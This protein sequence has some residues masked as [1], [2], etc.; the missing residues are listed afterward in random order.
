MLFLLTTVITHFFASF[1]LFGAI[2]VV[3]ALL[4]KPLKNK[5]QNYERFMSKAM[6]RGYALMVS[7]APTSVALLLILN[8]TG[9]KWNKIF[10]PG[11]CLAIIGILTSA[12]LEKRFDIDSNRINPNEETEAEITEREAWLSV[13][14]VV[15]VI[16][17]MI[18][19]IYFL[20]KLEMFSSFY[21]VMLA[22]LV[23]F[24]L[25]LNKFRNY[26]NLKI[27]LHRYWE[28][29]LSKMANLGV[30]FIAIGILAQAVENSGLINSL[31][32]LISIEKW[33]YFSLIIIPLFIIISSMIGLHP[34]VSVVFLGKVYMVSQSLIPAIGI[35]LAL[36]LGTVISFFFCPIEAVILVIAK[37]LNR[38]SKEVTLKWNYLFAIVFL[39]EGI[40]FIYVLINII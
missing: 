33:G 35:A 1:L 7:W 32:G 38:S 10:L 25:W 27:V 40:T 17:G 8:V 18:M 28:E 23:I 3:V 26:D 31:F 39:L 11:F 5:V 24:C 22:A 36:L 29:E 6:S 34:L 9:L 21:C 14:D 37:F 30:L 12:L 19:L 15:L 4:G 2:P 13:K 20:E 16:S